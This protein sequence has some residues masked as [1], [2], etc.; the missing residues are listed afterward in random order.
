MK[1]ITFNLANTNLINL[2][3]IDYINDTTY[4]HKQ[5]Q[6]QKRLLHFALMK[7]IKTQ[8]NKRSDILIKNSK[9]KESFPKFN[10]LNLLPYLKKKI[11]Q[12]EYEKNPYFSTYYQVIGFPDNKNY[13]SKTNNINEYNSKTNTL[14]AQ[15]RSN[16]KT[17]I[18]DKKR[19]KNRIKSSF[20]FD[21]SKYRKILGDSTDRNKILIIIQH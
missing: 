13:Y 8:Y 21:A 1:N 16:K 19:Y 7:F 2:K 5:N 12:K 14:H 4:V 9:H 10:N 3:K 20:A 6:E 17:E 15:Q 11:H 18:K